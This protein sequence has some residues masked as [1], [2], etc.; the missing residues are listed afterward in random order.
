MEKHSQKIAVVVTDRET[1]AQIKAVTPDLIELRADL[2]KSRDVDYIRRQIKLRRALRVP[3]LLTVRNQKK[4]GA[5]L[6]FS[7]AIKQGILEA[8]LP[9]VDWVD[10]ELSSKLLR[11]T[12]VL[13]RSLKKRVIVSSHDFQRTPLHLDA[14]YKKSMSARA[15]IVKIAA[16]AHSASDVWRMLDVTRSHAGRIITMSLGPVG[17]ISRIIFPSAGSCFTYTYVGKPT[18]P[19]QIDA[20]TLRSHLKFYYS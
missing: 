1:N 18:A 20:K 15:D 9:H 17:K 11:S 2:F 10:I 14:I 7:D 19:G 4:E 12:V 13:A 8:C 6:E 3:I 16:F 5:R